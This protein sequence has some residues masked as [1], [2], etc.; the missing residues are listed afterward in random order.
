MTVTNF[1]NHITT[2]QFKNQEKNKKKLISA[3]KKHIQE[4]KGP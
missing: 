3:L 1:F 2:G 4:L